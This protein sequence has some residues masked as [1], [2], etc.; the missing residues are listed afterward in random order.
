MKIANDAF[1][2][3]KN[4]SRNK[5]LCKE[6]NVFRPVS[7]LRAYHVLSEFFFKKFREVKGVIITSYTVTKPYHFC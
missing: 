4:S 5:T 2:G 1:Q 6:R 3:A 7:Q